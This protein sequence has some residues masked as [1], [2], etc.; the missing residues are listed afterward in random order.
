MNTKSKIAVALTLS[1]GIAGYVGFAETP[2]QQ[3]SISKEIKISQLV[4][5]Q[6]EMGGNVVT[7]IMYPLVIRPIVVTP[8]PMPL[9]IPDPKPDEPTLPK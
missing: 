6:T 4:E 1:A 9:P 8:M 2:Y 3:S 5:Q 7:I